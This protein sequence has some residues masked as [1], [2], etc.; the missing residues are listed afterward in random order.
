MK[1]SLEW[2]DEKCTN[3]AHYEVCHYVAECLNF[4]PN[5]TCDHYSPNKK[6]GE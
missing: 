3:C 6:E 5:F 4:I 1:A 2:Y